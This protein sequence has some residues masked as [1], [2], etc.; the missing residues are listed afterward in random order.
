MRKK[1]AKIAVIAA[2][3]MMFSGAVGATAQA[4]DG[5]PDKTYIVESDAQCYAWGKA[6]VESGEYKGFGCMVRADGRWDLD[7]MK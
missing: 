3:V 5:V 6:F 1:F 2:G 4:A 7:L